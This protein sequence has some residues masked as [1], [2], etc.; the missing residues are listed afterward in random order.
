MGTMVVIELVIGA[1]A[2]AS[3]LFGGVFHNAYKDE[4]GRVLPDADHE[5]RKG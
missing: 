5:K 2:G 1:V 3:V 4:D